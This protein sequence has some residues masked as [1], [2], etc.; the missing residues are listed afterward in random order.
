[1]D[2]RSGAAVQESNRFRVEAPERLLDDP[3]GKAN[4]ASI[5]SPPEDRLDSWKRIATY[6]KRDVSTVQR[7]E[8]R[9]AMPVHRHLHDKL[10][11]VFAFR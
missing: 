10:G 1:M 8:R 3:Q 5:R 6:L 7:W 11:S 4:T 2:C 9:E